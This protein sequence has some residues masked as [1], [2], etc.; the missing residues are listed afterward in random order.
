[1]AWA[2]L[3]LSVA[4]TVTSMAA[5]DEAAQADKRQNYRNAQILEK[6]ADNVIGSGQRQMLLERRN[7]DLVASRAIALSAAS[8][9]DLSSPDIVN[10]LA[11]IEGEGAYRESVALYEAEQQ[12]AD[13]REEARNLR[14]GIKSIESASKTRQTATALKGAAS[15]YDIYSRQNPR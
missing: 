5:E 8:G 14:E 15:A 2:P 13:M 11:D 7:T 6:K 4:S 10:I 9:S 1:M 3:A 12:A